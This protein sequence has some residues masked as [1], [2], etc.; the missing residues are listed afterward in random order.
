MTIRGEL[1]EISHPESVTRFIPTGAELY[2]QGEVCHRCFVLLDGWVA[3][4]TLLDD[5]SCQI[6]DFTAPGALLGFQLAPNVP[7][8]HSARCLTAVRICAYPRSVFDKLVERN[9]RLAFLLFRQAS[10]DEARA[11]DHLVNVSLRAARERIAHLLLELYVKVRHQLPIRPHETILLP[12]TQTDIG[13][14]VGLTGVHVSRTL[15]VLREQG[16]VRLA[17]HMLEIVD[18]IAFTRAAGLETDAPGN[19]TAGTC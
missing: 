18:P 3:L 14:A 7:M 19:R 5:G 17:N 9:S 12:L 10:S 4:S 6:L 15:R 1:A 8:Y 16:I 2:S 11:H 13:Q